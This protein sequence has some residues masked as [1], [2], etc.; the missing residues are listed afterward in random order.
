M[1]LMDVA[2]GELLGED[3]GAITLLNGQTIYVDSRVKSTGGST[4]TVTRI[5]TDGVFVRWDEAGYVTDVAPESLTVIGATTIPQIAGPYIDKPTVLAVQKALL[6]KGFSVGKSG[7]DG[8]WGKDTAAGIKAFQLANSFPVTA[9]IDFGVLNALKVSP[10]KDAPTRTEAGSSASA[11]AKDV[12]AVANNAAGEAAKA[13]T[14]VQVQ[15]IVKVI[16]TAADAQ[17]P[18][19]PAVQAEV[20]AA[21]KKAQAAK[22]PEEVKAAAQAVEAAGVSVMK[23]AQP[24]WWVQPV[25]IGSPVKRWHAVAGA[26]VMT[27]LSTVLIAVLRRKK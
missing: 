16:Q 12:A 4:G 20:K 6:A 8:L 17:P 11:A 19:P 18:A 27:V 13:D 1:S 5:T 2:I 14:P 23:A 25:W 21:A 24:G 22:T 7:A 15:E 10:P 9:V 26:G 3:L